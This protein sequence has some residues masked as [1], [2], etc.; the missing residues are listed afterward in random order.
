[1]SRQE[2]YEREHDDAADALEEA[3]DA[4]WVAYDN[5]KQLLDDDERNY[6]DAYIDGWRGHQSNDIT[7]Q[8]R[9]SVVDAL[10]G[11]PGNDLDHAFN[12]DSHCRICGRAQ[13]EH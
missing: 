5:A 12:G 1:M 11:G 4:L 10:R 6:V 9:D 2:A 13:R 7:Q 8:M 3:I